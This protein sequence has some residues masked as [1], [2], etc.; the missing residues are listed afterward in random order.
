M[1]GGHHRPMHPRM[2]RAT[3]I[4]LALAALAASA[5]SRPIVAE[6]LRRAEPQLDGPSGELPFTATADAVETETY[7]GALWLRTR[8]GALV[9]VGTSA[10]G[11][12]RHLPSE[13]V[14]GLHH[15][16]TNK[17]WALA[18][19]PAT[20]DVRLW[21]RNERGWHAAVEL[22]GTG[23]K[24]LAV[25]DVAGRPVIMTTRAVVTEVDGA[26]A[27]TPLAEPL[28]D[29]F[30]TGVS[31]ARTGGG[32]LVLG[33]RSAT[34]TKGRLVAIDEASGSVRDIHPH[35]EG[36]R[37]LQKGGWIGEVQCAAVQGVVVDPADDKCALVAMAG[38]TALQ[39]FCPTPRDPVTGPWQAIV[40]ERRVGLPL[41][42]A[43][44]IAPVVSKPLCMGDPAA[45]A[46]EMP[47]REAEPEKA[48]V[49]ALAR[50]GDA[51]WIGMDSV[52]A[53]YVAGAP[54]EL[55][56]PAM[57]GPYLRPD[58]ADYAAAMA[59]APNTL[60][61]PGAACS[62]LDRTVPYDVRP[63]E[64]V[65][66]LPGCFR[67][68][69]SLEVLCLDDTRFTVSDGGVTGSVRSTID[70]VGARSARLTT[71]A[72]VSARIWVEYDRGLIV[73]EDERRS[74]RG[75]FLI[76]L[77]PLEEAEALKANGF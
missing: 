50:A 71:E 54:V 30:A 27:A 73:R 29:D 3:G 66:A 15:T 28:S 32:T 45:C 55:H 23:A 8:D 51:L 72:G 35:C 62:I 49:R 43:T 39:R 57:R 7:E 18:V 38:S 56:L 60:C 70:F 21:E 44:D 9:S 76:R 47:M 11:L 41:L 42:F 75:T 20:E 10:K 37:N 24:P 61:T 14:V 2:T 25:L 77:E 31:V 1:N 6:P 16:S 40:F 22:L 48:S 69:D 5:C 74:P 52:V 19:D 58:D 13:V 4:T 67:P 46:S 68:T 33:S 12:E 34:G 53:R 26:L 65:A 63:V 17:L 36:V 59:I 64:D